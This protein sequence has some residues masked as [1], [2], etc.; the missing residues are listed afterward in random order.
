M[1]INRLILG[2]VPTIGMTKREL[3]ITWI[4]TS[5]AFFDKKHVDKNSSRHDCG[6]LSIE[7][8]QRKMKTRQKHQALTVKLEVL[9]WD[10]YAIVFLPNETPTLQ[11]IS[12]RCQ[13]KVEILLAAPTMIP[14]MRPSAKM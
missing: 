3:D 11:I 13:T 10:F 14:F 12:R 1:N 8:S 4:D 7:T 6:R 2:N 9:L 5:N